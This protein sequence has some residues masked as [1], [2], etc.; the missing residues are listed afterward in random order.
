MP[1]SEREARWWVVAYVLIVLVQVGA[2]VA[3][4][5]ALLRSDP[6]FLLGAGFA[7]ATLLGHLV[8]G[9]GI[10]NVHF[11]SGDDPETSR[12]R[13]HY[14]LSKSLRRL[15]DVSAAWDFT[16]SQDASRG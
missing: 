15:S 2:V 14:E 3:V 8:I 11:R 6:I 1:N 10:T 12:I 7:A 5:G 9:V 16:R 4:V 13:T